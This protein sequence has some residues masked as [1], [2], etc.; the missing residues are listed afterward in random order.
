MKVAGLDMTDICTQCPGS[1]RQYSDF[2]KSTCGVNSGT[3]SPVIFH[4][5]TITYS[6]V[7]GKIKA[8][9]K[10][11]TNA[12]YPSIS[13]PSINSNYVDGISLT[14]GDP[15]KHIWTFAAALGEVGTFPPVNCP[16]INVNQ[17]KLIVPH[18]LL[19]LR[20]IIISVIQ[21]IEVVFNL[22]HSSQIIL[23][24]MELVVG[25]TTH[26]VL[27]IILHGSTKSYHSQHLMILR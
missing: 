17:T 16:C 18:L 2:N 3:C 13:N 6:K 10:G 21:E 9:Q 1:L 14:Y 7:C 4:T 25:V 8:Y 27:S 20:E 11:S 23:F 19:I 12:F 24:G 5:N 22:I 15:K 26:V